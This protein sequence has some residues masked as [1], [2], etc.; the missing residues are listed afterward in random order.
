M[1]FD[2]KLRLFPVDRCRSLSFVF[3]IDA[4][5]WL[6][7]WCSAWALSCHQLYFLNNNYYILIIISTAYRS[8]KHESICNVI[9]YILFLFLYV[10]IY[11][12]NIY[13]IIFYFS[14]HSSISLLIYH[15]KIEIL[16]FLNF[17]CIYWM[18]RQLS[19][20]LLSKVYPDPQ[21]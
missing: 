14:C 2:F 18:R 8:Y 7:S 6:I 13:F 12:L 4:K 17:F 19:C 15:M 20:I 11:I 3:R 1:T 5:L 21:F 9:Y 16:I 10:Y